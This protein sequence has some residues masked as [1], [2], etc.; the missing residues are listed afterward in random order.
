MSKKQ[1]AAYC[2]AIVLF[3]VTL[4]VS[5][6]PLAPIELLVNGASNPLAIDREATRF[7]WMS[8]GAARGETQTAYRILVA[9]TAAHLARAQADSWDSGKVESDKSA[10]V[11]YAGKPLPAAKRFW[12]QVRVWDQTGQASPY[13]APAF[14]DTG[15]NQHEWVAHYIWDGTTN[16]NNFAYFR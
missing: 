7:T 14:F 3:T 13:S 8:Q 2:F 15:L 11:E 12:W 10:S 16:L 6:E 1:K 4:E 9:S 5:G